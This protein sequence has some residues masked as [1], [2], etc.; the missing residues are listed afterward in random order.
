[1]FL[2]RKEIDI[3]IY[4]YVYIY[5]YCSC[6]MVI[7]LTLGRVQGKVASQVETDAEIQWKLRACRGCSSIGR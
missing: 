2:Y 6:N 3:A 7:G 5:M 1:M 4:I